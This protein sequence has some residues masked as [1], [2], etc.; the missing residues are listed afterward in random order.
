[1]PFTKKLTGGAGNPRLSVMTR[2]QREKLR[3]DKNTRRRQRN[4]FQERMEAAKQGR[5]MKKR[6]RQQKVREHQE[7]IRGLDVG[8]KTTRLRAYTEYCENLRESYDNKHKEV[9]GATKMIEDIKEKLDRIT[10]D[11]LENLDQMEDL[12][13]NNLRLNVNTSEGEDAPELEDMRL[14]LADLFSLIPD[15]ESTQRKKEALE[16]MVKEQNNWVRERE[17]NN[18]NITTKIDDIRRQIER[19]RLLGETRPGASSGRGRGK[20]NN[21]G[22][23]NNSGSGG[24]QVRNRQPELNLPD[25]PVGTPRLN[26]PQPERVEEATLTTAPAMNLRNNL[27]R[28]RNNRNPNTKPISLQTAKVIGLVDEPVRPG[29]KDKRYRRSAA[30]KS[31]SNR[32]RRKSRRN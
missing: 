10:L 8:D 32:S 25:A 5:E 21:R 26:T 9:E 7:G 18:G 27:N 17:R 6:A 28:A 30:R 16:N 23:G 24:T 12:S 3:R 29:D 4:N 13:N 14:L 31:P 1:M 11:V 19:L 2:Q 15:S 20:G 22:R